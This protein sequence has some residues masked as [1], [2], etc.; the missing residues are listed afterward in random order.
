MAQKKTV[1]NASK[2][3]HK[4]ERTTV[5]VRQE[6][7]DTFLGLA[8]A[9]EKIIS[10]LLQFYIGEFNQADI[11]KFDFTRMKRINDDEF[12]KIATFS[13]APEVKIRLQEIKNTVNEMLAVSKLKK[14]KTSD[15]P[16]VI[17]EIPENKKPQKKHKLMTSDIIRYIVSVALE[18]ETKDVESFEEPEKIRV[19]IFLPEND[20][21]VVQRYAEEKGI[22]VNRLLYKHFPSFTDEDFTANY[23][24]AD[25]G[26]R[27]ASRSYNNPDNDPRGPWAA[28]ALVGFATKDLRQDLHYPLE[29][30]ETGAVYSSPKNGWR[31]SKDRMAELIKDGRIEWPTRKNGQPVRKKFI[32]EVP[33]DLYRTSINV[34]AG[35]YPR[36]KEM[37]ER[38]NVPDYDILRTF[39]MFL[40][41]KIGKNQ[42]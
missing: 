16:P 42:L 2:P 9:Q 18:R 25:R 27:T 36:L 31:Y 26:R 15:M 32:S 12:P 11:K 1:P 28:E 22:P 6:D 19:G 40:A 33:A 4:M 20:Y 7:F 5:L 35:M 8:K 24:P 38:L 17:E 39:V 41:G 3:V 34:Y 30:N 29:N 13:I 14:R 10:E 21:K 37:I 23:V